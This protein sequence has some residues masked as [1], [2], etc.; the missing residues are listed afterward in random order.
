MSSYHQ[1]HRIPSLILKAMMTFRLQ[2]LLQK[3]A[4]V[5]NSINN[6]WMQIDD[7]VPYYNFSILT[8]QQV[9]DKLSKDIINL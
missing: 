4:P 5:D 1:L 3:M 6:S 8:D 9:H 7:T 2:L